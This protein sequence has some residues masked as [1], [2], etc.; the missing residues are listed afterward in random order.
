MSEPLR[1]T[2]VGAGAWGSAL[3][4]VLAENG[5]EV[6]IWSYEAH[7]ASAINEARSNPYL[8]GVELP[9]GLRAET[10]LGA[11][12]RGAELIVSAS[13]SQFVR[14]V[15]GEA[16]S[17]L[18]PDALLVSATKGVELGTLRR[19][20]EVLDEILPPGVMGRF[21]ALSGPSFAQE[22]AARAPTAVVIG[23][24]DAASAARAQDLFQSGWFR[25][26]TNTDVIG[27]E[28]GGALKNVVALA[29][30]ATAGLGYGHNTMAAL[31]TRGLAEITRLG[32]AVGAEKATFYGLAGLGDL[33]LTCTG[34][35][36]RNRT[37]GYR[38]GRGETLEE[39][40]SEMSAVAEGVKTAEA[41]YEL[42]RRHGVEMPITEQMHAILY[43]GRTP[44]DALRSLMSRDPKPE[45]WS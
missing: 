12:V 32:L 30:G 41:A 22:V 9:E 31:I 2:V 38:L 5:H 16:A 44:N 14:G 21:C 17:H 8:E 15:M 19:M 1:A 26:Y 27:V 3:A 40:L 7:V 13:P 45:E 35:L 24:R 39:I 28:L 29:A 18:E 42:A 6:R 36:S 4:M 43:E 20:D 33:V 10:D 23:S 34:S 37:V 11:A 25:V